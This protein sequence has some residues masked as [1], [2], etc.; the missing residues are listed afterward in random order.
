MHARWEGD[1]AVRLAWAPAGYRSLDRRTGPNREERFGS[2]PMSVSLRC[3]GAVARALIESLLGLPTVLDVVSSIQSV[4]VLLRADAPC[5]PAFLTRVRGIAQDALWDLGSRAWEG[6]PSLAGE[7]GDVEAGCL[8]IPVRYGG[9]DGPDLDTV[10][11]WAGIT[12]TEVVRRHTSRV[13]VCFAVGFRPGM[14]FLGPVDPGIAAPR[15]DRPRLEVPAGSVALAGEQTGVY[16]T[17][18]SGGWRLLGRTSR[19]LFDVTGADAD[20]AC[21]VHPGDRV[22]FQVDPEGDVLPW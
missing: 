12:S 15:L 3:A 11:A 7:G 13:Y 22:R 10:A 14:P 2:L 8:T 1:R 20:G 6:D 17:P 18:S 16:P 19:T 4:V 9:E 21:L 5:D